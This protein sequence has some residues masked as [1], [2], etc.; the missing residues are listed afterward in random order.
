[1]LADRAGRPS[2]VPQYKVFRLLAGQLFELSGEDDG[3]PGEVI[4]ALS[5]VYFWSHA[6]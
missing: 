4:S 3:L 5:V 1:L 6:E 2:T